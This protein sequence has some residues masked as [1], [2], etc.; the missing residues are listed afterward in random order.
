MMQHLHRQQAQDIG[1]A[2]GLSPFEQWQRFCCTLAPKDGSSEIWL[3]FGHNQFFVGEFSHSGRFDIWA[4]KG[5][6]AERVRTDNLGDAYTHLSKLCL[7]QPG[8]AFYIPTQPIGSPTKE[9]VATTDDI[10]IE[11]DSISRSEQ[12][13]QYADFSRVT[14]LEW[15]M[16]IGSGGK[17]VHAHLKLD[18]HRPVEQVQPLR[19]AT[20]LGL[21]A[22]PVT[23]RLHQPMRASG[24]YRKEKQ[25]YQELLS[26]SDARYTPE[27]IIAGLKKWFAHLDW[28]FPDSLSEAWWREKFHPL[29]KGS[30]NNT[31][32]HKL[33]TARE[34]L[35][36]GEAG[37]LADKAAAQAVRESR[38]TERRLYTAQQQLTGKVSLVDLVTQTEERLGADAFNWSGHNWKFSGDHARGCCP[39]HQSA[40]GSS[41]W[42]APAGD[43]WAFHCT[44][45]TDDKPISPF[46]YWLY[47]KNGFNTPYPRGREWVEAAKQ[48]LSETGVAVPDLVA[49]Q[50]FSESEYT[51]LLGQQ[52]EQ[53]RLELAQEEHSESLCLIESLRRGGKSKRKRRERVEP[54]AG[55]NLTVYYEPGC[56]PEYKAALELPNYLLRSI[57]DRNQFFA[58][59]V[60]KGWS[61]VL[62]ASGT[63]SG[64]SYRAGFL[65]PEKI[66]VDQLYYFTKESRNPSTPTI[67]ANFTELPTRHNGQV[68]AV[69][70]KT[71]LGKSVMRVVSEST[72]ESG[73]GNCNLAPF[74]NSVQSKGYGWENNNP[75]CQLCEWSEFCGKEQG[76]GF[77]FKH[78]RGVALR[79]PRIRLHPQSAPHDLDQKDA[80]IWEEIGDLSTTKT[81]AATPAQVNEQWARIE[82]FDSE[83][84]GRLAPIR[85]AI[86]EAVRHPQQSW[87]LDECDRPKGGCPR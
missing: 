47:L 6:G 5:A 20:C 68:P 46:A 43:G 28:Q 19:R 2:V 81:I 56:L 32:Q 72:A 50:G 57:D 16:L 53:E 35:A 79:Q 33:D 52:A 31:E 71:P 64:K 37:F 41:G 12:L 78:Q 63:G 67:E 75:L 69:G 15:A 17:S 73:G 74:F 42:I 49:E 10:G 13:E 11:L 23:V 87:W 44:A 14:G 58:E 9:A 25:S 62:D 24:L 65:T 85:T 26:A 40:S 48:F 36:A 80:A 1:G 34:L 82:E 45:C 66:G 54:I 70:K 27:Q 39:F 30:A 21:R 51:A 22:D 55:E 3:K 29:L 38:E 61:H 4:T 18:E 60:S 8:G 86:R 76:I 84:Y 7:E 83:L 59:A 77:G